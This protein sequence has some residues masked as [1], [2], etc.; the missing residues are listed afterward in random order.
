[1][2]LCTGQLAQRK[3]QFCPYAAV[4]KWPYQ[5]LRAEEMKMVSEK[6]FAW[7]AFRERGWNLYYI[8]TLLGDSEKPLLLIPQNEVEQLFNEIEKSLGIYASFPDVSEVPGFQLS[9]VEE[10]TPRPRYLGRFTEDCGMLELEGMIPVEGSPLEA[11]EVLDERSF[12]FF[13]QKMLDAMAASKKKSKAVRQKKRKDRVE[14]KRRWCSELKR[15]QCYL[16]LR[17]RGTDGKFEDFHK[18]SNMSHEESQKAQE[19]FELAAGIKLP[20]L[21]MTS[22]APYDFDKNVIF[23][24]V[25]IEVFEKDHRKITEIG[26]CTLDTLDIVRAPPG[27]GGKRWMNHLRC[28]HF[29][30]V[31]TAHLNNS[32]FVAGCADRFQPEFGTSEWISTQ[33]I[34]Q[35]VASCFKPPY[36]E[37]G[38][39]TPYP[40]SAKE[41]PRGGSQYKPHVEADPSHRRNVVLLGHGVRSDLDFLRNVGYDVGN[42]SNMIEV[43]DTGNM[44]RAYKHELNPISLGALLMELE[45][46]GWNLHNA[47]NDAVYTTQALLGL[48]IAALSPDNKP[49][50]K[51][52]H[53]QLH[54]VAAEA[55]D[56]LQDELE[57][58]E[59]IEEEGGDGGE[60]VKILPMAE[61]VD[62][63]SFQRAKVK[64]RKADEQRARRDARRD[65][66]IGKAN[67]MVKAT[68][69][70]TDGES[71]PRNLH[72]PKP[73][74]MP[75]DED[76]MDEAFEAATTAARERGQT[77]LVS[78]ET[79]SELHDGLSSTLSSPVVGT[80]DSSSWNSET[81]PTPKSEYIPPHLRSPMKK[82]APSPASTEKAQVE[83]KKLEDAQWKSTDNK[84]EP[85]LSIAE[86]MKILD[87]MEEK[88]GMSTIESDAADQENVDGGV[89]M[90]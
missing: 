26:F 18:D 43:L 69:T 5:H 13:R 12:P 21:D 81:A 4:T 50:T 86:R 7:G 77:N 67:R 52:S 53:E 84:V 11:P 74:S 35:V 27:E 73:T 17:P 30:I 40:F 14:N 64:G 57:D 80:T 34:P 23:V 89:V 46:V 85:P 48:S 2:D 79:P 36:S 6:Y 63:E 72:Q 10:G 68:R 24:C 87:A 62:E 76:A 78:T 83:T 31:E 59:A 37:P 44:Y 70:P 54:E 47:G 20:S 25:D 49:A 22:A 60:P 75:F 71:K 58:W 8:R 41:V 61:L 56:R 32:E 19:D 38:K 90:L 29:R 16:G 9:F 88:H 42:L 66:G 33:E 1:M 65:N 45:L 3:D 15:G 55:R 82:K 28:R 39:Y 51:L